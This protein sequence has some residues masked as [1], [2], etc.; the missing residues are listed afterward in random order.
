MT[1]NKL[2]PSAVGFGLLTHIII[3]RQDLAIEYNLN[4]F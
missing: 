4:K 3:R 1:Q 2:Q